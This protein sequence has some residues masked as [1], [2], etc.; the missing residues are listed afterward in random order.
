[1]LFYLLQLKEMGISARGELLIP[2]EKKRI[3]VILDE[4]A[5]AEIRGAVGHIE[6][7]V[8]QPLPPPVKKI[9]YCR[10]CAYGEFCWS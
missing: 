7:L 6:E 8:R 10:Q 5:E 9:K 3:E 2:E 1:L 4:K